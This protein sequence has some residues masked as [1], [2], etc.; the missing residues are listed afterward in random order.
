MSKKGLV[1]GLFCNCMLVV[2][3]DVQIGGMTA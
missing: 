3:D 1:W 2:M